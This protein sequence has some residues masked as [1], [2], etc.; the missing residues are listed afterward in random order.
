M[1]EKFFCFG[2]KPER[3]KIVV[4]PTRHYWVSQGVVNN[5]IQVAGTIYME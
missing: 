2:G 4:A 5:V 3:L 1:N